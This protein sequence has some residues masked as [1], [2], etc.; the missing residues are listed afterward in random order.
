MALDVVRM[1]WSDERTLTLRSTTFANRSGRAFCMLT[2]IMYGWP[3]GTVG[4]VK[5]STMWIHSL[6]YFGRLKGG[7][8]CI[9]G[10]TCMS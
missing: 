1:W 10:A 9:R 5:Q 8:L 4:V 7:E 3:Q 2:L 6:S